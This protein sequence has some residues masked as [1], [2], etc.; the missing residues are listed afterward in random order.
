MEGW[1]RVPKH[2]RYCG[3]RFFVRLEPSEDEAETEN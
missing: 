1:D 2:C 3:K